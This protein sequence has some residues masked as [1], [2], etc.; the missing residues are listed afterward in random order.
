MKQV[1]STFPN[2]TKTAN[3]YTVQNMKMDTGFMNL[4]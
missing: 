4:M 2:E 3:T 1:G